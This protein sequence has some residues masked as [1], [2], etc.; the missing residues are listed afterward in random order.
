MAYQNTAAEIRPELN[1]VLEEALAIDNYLIGLDILPVHTVDRSSGEYRKLTMTASEL[2]RSQDAVRASKSAYPEVDWTWEKDNYR[3]ID[4][5]L[6]QKIDDVISADVSQ[7]FDLEAQAS[8]QLLRRVRLA[9]EQRVAAKVF[10]ASNFDAVAAG[11]AYTLA[12]KATMD[13]AEDTNAALKRIR[14]RGQNPN[15][16]VLNRDVWDRVRTS[17]LL[18]KFFF[19]ALGGGQQITLDMVAKNFGLQS[20]KIADAIYDT[21]DK[22]KTA[23]LAYIWANTHVWIGEVA[24]GDFAAGG[25]GRTLVWT[26]DTGGST[27]VTETYRDEDKRSDVIR[28]RSNMDEKIVMANAGTLITTNFA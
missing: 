2:A 17:D 18:A 8:K 5:G 26:G 3:T 22:G 9:H 4:R 7:A 6:I 12:N 19:G 11:A 23:S 20:V 28:V 25:A 15:T 27:F 13:F 1:S 24:G 10:N 21:A 14:M 16:M